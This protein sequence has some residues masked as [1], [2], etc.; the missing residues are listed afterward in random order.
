MAIV[1][2]SIDTIKYNIFVKMD[3]NDHQSEIGKHFK[4][5]CI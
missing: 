4:S 3:I 5:L 2:D 1:T